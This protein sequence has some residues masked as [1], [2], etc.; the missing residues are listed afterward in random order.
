M[1]EIKRELKLTDDGSHTLYV[2]EFDEH[3]HSTY[4]AIQESIHIFLNAGFY[5]SKQNPLRILE[6]GFGTGLNCYLTAKA[7]NKQKREVIYHA[8]ELHPLEKSCTE[9]LNYVKQSNSKDFALF[10]K[11]HDCPWEKKIRISE[12]FELQKLQGDLLTCHLPMKYDLVY[13][14][15]FSP[16]VQ[17]RLW[18]KDVFEKIYKAS[19][20]NAIL[21][22][23]CTKGIVKRALQLAGFG[24]EKLPGPKGKREMLRAKK[25]AKSL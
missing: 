21:T 9:K 20:A 6:V 8:I 11:I 16:N 10:K 23:Y 1:P 18:S 22:T 2:P 4:G 7:T 5:H 25:Q 15:A 13:F 12:H 14:D 19:N 17:P 24:I 3:Y